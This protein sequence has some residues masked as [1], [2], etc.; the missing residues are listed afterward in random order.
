MSRALRI[1]FQLGAETFCS[2]LSISRGTEP[3]SAM[4]LALFILLRS[5]FFFPLGF[6]QWWSR[7]DRVLTLNINI[8]LLLFLSTWSGAR[9]QDSATCAGLGHGRDYSDC[10][11]SEQ[12]SEKC[13]AF[14]FPWIVENTWKIK[15]TLES[16]STPFPLSALDVEQYWTG[17]PDHP[18]AIF[19]YPYIYHWSG[20]H[21]VFKFCNINF[22]FV[23]LNCAF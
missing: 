3:V 22:L 23:H 17:A 8:W 21:K 15:A 9:G 4:T 16:F 7:A 5:L 13:L 6:R 11:A 12:N 19:T 10:R 14:S 20:Q 18:H 1:R 2:P